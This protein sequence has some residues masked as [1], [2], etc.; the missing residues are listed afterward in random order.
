[1][2][3][4]NTVNIPPTKRSPDSSLTLRKVNDWTDSAELPETVDHEE[5]V[6][7]EE[8][9][10]LCSDLKHPSVPGDHKIVIDLDLHAQLIPSTTPDHFHLLI[11]KPLARD[12]YFEILDVLAKHGILET[13]YVNAAK[14]RGYTAVR[15]PWIKKEVVRR[16][17][18]AA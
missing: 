12:D 5:V 11:D 15:L 18:L 8:A 3:S 7:I 14:Q 13:G 2:M 16:C 1:M 6:G 10:V 9:N 4:I 17:S